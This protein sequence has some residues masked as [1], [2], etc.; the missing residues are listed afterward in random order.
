MKFL[1]VSGYSMSLRL[2]GASFDSFVF[3]RKLLHYAK[4]GSNLR[5]RRNGPGIVLLNIGLFYRVG[6]VIFLFSFFLMGLA[7]S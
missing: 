2:E 3:F 1:N 7:K 4:K 5:T 6:Q